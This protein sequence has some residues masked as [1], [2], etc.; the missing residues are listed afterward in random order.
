MFKHKKM[1]I[2]Y[3]IPQFINKIN[4]VNC[5]NLTDKEIDDI[6]SGYAENAATI[7]HLKNLGLILL[8]AEKQTINR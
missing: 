6:C 7:F 2:P 8:Q 4:I 3:Q 1:C 5:C